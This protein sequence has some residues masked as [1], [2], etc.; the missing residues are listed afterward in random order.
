[1]Q[2]YFVEG[3]LKKLLCTVIDDIQFD[4]LLLLMKRKNIRK[5]KI[6]IRGV[7][8]KYRDCMLCTNNTCNSDKSFVF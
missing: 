4:R 8:E 1:M 3:A 6:D 2:F 7:F 5:K